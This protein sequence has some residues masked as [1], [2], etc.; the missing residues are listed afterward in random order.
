VRRFV[1]AKRRTFFP[2]CRVSFRRR[3]AERRRRG[4]GRGCPLRPAGAPA[5]AHVRRQAH[6]GARC[7]W[8][9]VSLAVAVA[10]PAVGGRSA[11]VPPLDR[12]MARVA[13]RSRVKALP[14]SSPGPR[15]A[16]LRPAGGPRTV[17][18]APCRLCVEAAP[19]AD[20]FHHRG[21]RRR[22]ASP[23]PRLLA[24]LALLVASCPLRPWCRIRRPRA[25]PP[26]PPR[27]LPRQVNQMRGAPGGV[28]AS[29]WAWTWMSG[30]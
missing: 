18:L 23:W 8:R 12:R 3:M 15:D 1:T 17:S 7:V 24:L 29:A 19:T 22:K 11:V 14:P 10:V 9:V 26:C 25:F 28:R 27:T 16:R 6:Q 2:A 30:A 20:S 5:C 21:M 13:P 4:D